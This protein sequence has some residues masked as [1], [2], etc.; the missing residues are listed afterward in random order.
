MRSR[1]WSQY[2]R[3]VDLS[4][5]KDHLELFEDLEISGS[6]IESLIPMCSAQDVIT[7][8]VPQFYIKHPGYSIMD[9]AS[10]NG[11]LSIIADTQTV[12]SAAERRADLQ[13]VY[14][15]IDKPYASTEELNAKYGPYLNFEWRVHHYPFFTMLLELDIPGEVLC[16]LKDTIDAGGRRHDSYE[17]VIVELLPMLLSDTY[18][19]FEEKHVTEVFR[20]S[21]CADLVALR[22][23]IFDI[24]QRHPVVRLPR[25]IAAVYP[26]LAELDSVYNGLFIGMHIVPD[27]YIFFDYL[28]ESGVSYKTL[29]SALSELPD[30]FPKDFIVKGFPWINHHYGFGRSVDYVGAYS[31]ALCQPDL[32]IRQIVDDT[33]VSDVDKI[34]ASTL[35]TLPP[36]MR[37]EYAGNDTEVV[38]K[39]L[40][41]LAGIKY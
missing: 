7:A 38:L 6:F 36:S 11:L 5:Y 32:A 17:E 22:K 18:I 28:L 41:M 23:L 34:V 2:L 33:P 12:L 39:Y 21:E 9:Y 27:E 15:T 13:T 19:D 20:A 24:V 37:S 8:V 1:Y 30:I 35:A 40:A 3:G 4:V 29:L 31:D 26:R 25:E 14:H 16:Y 10:A